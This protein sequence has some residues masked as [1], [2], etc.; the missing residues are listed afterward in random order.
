MTQLPL[1]DVPERWPVV[2]SERACGGAIVTLRD[3]VVGMPDGGVATR[4][5]VEHPGAVGIVAL[6]EEQRILM[7][8]QYRHPVA[9]M[10][11]ELPAGLCDVPGEPARATAERELLEETGYRAAQWHVLADYF[12][13]PGIST[14]RIW[15]F[16]ARGLSLVPEAEQNYVKIHE[17][18]QLTLT[19]VPLA[20]AVHRFL[21][22][23]LH[24]GVAGVGILSAYTATLNGFT[25]L[26]PAGATEG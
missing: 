8:R 17:E 4:Q 21:A 22:G 15:I 12:S 10:L 13:S 14:E 18:A 2:S 5:V 9:S 26:R 11:W 1:R 20:D 19:W 6:D 7:I 24:N 16:L 3:D 23:D 25:G